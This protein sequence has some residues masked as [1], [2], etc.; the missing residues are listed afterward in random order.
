MLACHYRQQFYCKGCTKLDI[1][2]PPSNMYKVFVSGF[3]VYDAPCFQCE[4]FY[5]DILLSTMYGEV[6]AG[7]M[8]KFLKLDL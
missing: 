4:H 5:Q 1:K 7:I 2:T 3:A 8:Y 6:L